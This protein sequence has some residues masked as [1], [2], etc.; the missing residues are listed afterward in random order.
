M[1]PR[2]LPGRARGEGHGC[3]GSPTRGRCRVVEI[4]SINHSRSNPEG[5]H[6][7]ELP[8]KAKP[9]AR[10]PESSSPLKE[11]V[12]SL[13][14]GASLSASSDSL[15]ERRC[16][17]EAGSSFPMPSAEAAE[18]EA[19]QPE[20]PAAEKQQP[21]QAGTRSDGRLKNG[22]VRAI[23]DRVAAQRLELQVALEL[24]AW[25]DWRESD[26]SAPPDRPL[27]SLGRDPRGGARGALVFPERRRQQQRQ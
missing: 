13:G 22:L 3:A 1:L 20:Q 15:S 23:P 11:G 18:V 25:P 24:A 27:S 2:G 17:S 5:F 6:G 12:A 21:Q 26:A 4:L 7:W 16:D 9:L 10:K 14:E 8:Q 19:I